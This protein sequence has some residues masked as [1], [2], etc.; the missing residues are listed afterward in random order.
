MHGLPTWEH[1]DSADFR[2]AARKDILQ[3]YATTFF[4]DVGIERIE[5]MEDGWDGKGDKGKTLFK[6]VDENG[7]EWWGRKVVLVSGVKDIM[8]DIKGYVE[9][10]VSGM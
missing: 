8:P 2:V 5:K 3:N 6:V 4:E 1:R 7:K 10:W 9:C